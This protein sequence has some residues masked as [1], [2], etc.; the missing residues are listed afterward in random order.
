LRKAGS[1]CRN[2]GR[3]PDVL[4]FVANPLA[5][6]GRFSPLAAAALIGIGLTILVDQVIHIENPSLFSVTFGGALLFAY[7]NQPSQQSNL[8]VPASLLSGLGLGGLLSSNDLT[9]GYLHSA[10]LFAGLALG[11]ATIYLLGDKIR[12]RWAIW[13]AAAL[14]VLAWVN[15]VTQAPWLKDTF[16]TIFHYTWPLALVAAGLWLIERSRERTDRAN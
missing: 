10:L 9:P 8:I 13:P 4:R 11:F 3:W 1:V 14:G 15:F 2:N 12:H 5:F 16:G 7:L 6:R